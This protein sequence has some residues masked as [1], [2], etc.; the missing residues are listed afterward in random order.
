MSRAPEAQGAASTGAQ[1]DDR[2]DPTDPSALAYRRAY[3]RLAIYGQ[4]QVLRCWPELDARGRARLLADLALV[5]LDALDRA[6]RAAPPHGGSAAVEPVREAVELADPRDPAAVA[7]GAQALREGRVAALLVAGGQGT[8]LGFAGPKGAYPLAPVS[9][10][11]LF[12]MHAQRLVALGRR[13]GAT[14]PLCVMTSPQNDAE[15]RALFAAQG[16]FGLPPERVC[17]FPQGVLPAVDE[18][19]RLLLADPDRLVMAANGNGG[20]FAALRDHGVLSRL[21]GW[22]CDVISYFHVDNA[23][24][25]SCDPRF[26][27]H[28]LLAGSEFS[29]KSIRRSE[30]GEAVG[31][32]ASREGRLCI[33][34]YTEIP[35]RLAQAYDAHGELVFCHGNPGLFLW[36]RDFVERQAERRDLPLHRAHKRIAHLDA[37]GQHISP[38]VP[39]GYKLE[40]FA[41]DTLPTAACAILVVCDRAEE[42]APVKQAEGA[43]SPQSARALLG[44]L[45]RRWAEAA[46]GRVAPGAQLEIDPRYALDAAELAERLPRGFV[47]HTDTYLGG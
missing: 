19:G 38:T 33:V 30:P 9:G 47:A 10:R 46:G 34:E 13:F 26:V 20:L 17:I 4:T 44:A 27:G 3:E 40:T 6:W 39:N 12:A 29:C 43:D 45:H 16:N 35:A 24:A 15:T 42:F 18:E 28:H 1:R 5:D 32:F 37:S 7:A 25:A 41:L 31:C 2:P 23:L 22:G 21:R 8:R 14:P 11:S 36:S